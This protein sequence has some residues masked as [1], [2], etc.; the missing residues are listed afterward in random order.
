MVR[1]GLDGLHA[2]VND[3][4]GLA[5]VLRRAIETE[6]LWESLVAGIQHPPGIAE[7][8]DRHLKLYQDALG[9]VPA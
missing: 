2:P 9:L 6:G 8:A 3:P 7:I 5:Q 1:D 4:A